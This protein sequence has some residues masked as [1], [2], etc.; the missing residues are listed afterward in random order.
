MVI[1][2]DGLFQAYTIDLD[3]GG[4]CSLIKEFPSV[5]VFLLHNES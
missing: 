2:A 5:D 4:E 1:T 3:N